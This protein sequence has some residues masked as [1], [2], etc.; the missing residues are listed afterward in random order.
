MLKYKIVLLVISPFWK[1]WGIYMIS[2]G[3]I[4]VFGLI[5]E[6][7][8][9]TALNTKNYNFKKKY[10]INVTKAKFVNTVIDWCKEN[11]EYPKYHKYY[12]TVE[13]RYYVNKKASGNYSSRNRIIRIFVNNHQ[14]IEELIDTCIH[15]YSHYLQMPR[16]SEQ[17][18]YNKYNKTKG[19]LNNPY[20]ID[21][22][23][24]AKFY[25]PKCIND[26]RKLGYI[27]KKGNTT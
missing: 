2:L 19:Y 17:L 6:A 18:E 24:K 1:W 23:E 5:I 14:T 8:K 11:M 4:Y 12:P 16:E 27:S 9:K 7:N 15:E 26:L 13:V 3:V 22:R 20:E 21:A 10:A 25:T